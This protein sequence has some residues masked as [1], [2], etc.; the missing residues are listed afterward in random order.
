[1][2][3]AVAVERLTEPIRQTR[4]QGAL[5]AARE[6]WRADSGGH[7][8]SDEQYE[9]ARRVLSGESLFLT[10][11]AGTGKSTTTAFVIDVLARA[12]LLDQTIICGTTG[13]AAQ[14]LSNSVADDSGA[15]ITA[16]TVHSQFKF[17]RIKPHR[18][19]AAK[20]PETET[21]QILRQAVLLII[22][23]ASM[24]RADLTDA[25]DM[26][27]RNARQ[28]DSLFGGITALLVGDLLQ[29]SPVPEQTKQRDKKTGELTGRK[30]TDPEYTK[31]FADGYFHRARNWWRSPRPNLVSLKQVHR[32]SDPADE[33]FVAA[34][35][36][37]RHGHLTPEDTAVINSRFTGR[38]K[39]EV[40]AEGVPI[41]CTNNE[42]MNNQNALALDAL[43]DR[44]G[45]DRQYYHAIVEGDVEPGDLK[46]MRVSQ[47]F[48][49]AVGARVM[50]TTND[51]HPRQYVNGS[52]GWIT[53]CLADDLV[54]RLDSGR[55][56]M[57]PRFLDEVTRLVPAKPTLDAHGK[58]RV[59]DE[60]KPLLEPIDRNDP[61][62]SEQIKA[63]RHT[64]RAT[65]G[66]VEQFPVKLGWAITVHKSQGQT[67]ERCFIADPSKVFAAGQMYVALSR[68]KSL[69]GL[70]LGEPLHPSTIK[71]TQYLVRLD[72]QAQLDAGRPLPTKLAFMSV[73]GRMEGP[74]QWWKPLSLSV[75]VCANGEYT[76]HIETWLH[77]GRIGAHRDGDEAFLGIPQGG[78]APAPSFAQVWEFI[79]P[80]L[81]GAA[82]V[83]DQLEIL[84]SYLSDAGAHA[85]HQP[86][87]GVPINVSD[88]EVGFESPYRQSHDRVLELM[89]WYNKLSPERQQSLLSATAAVGELDD[90]PR[91]QPVDAGAP[92]VYV[93][94]WA[95]GPE[96]FVDM[97]AADP[98]ARG[99]WALAGCP[100][101][102][103]GLDV[104]AAGA[105]LDLVS[106]TRDRAWT[107]GIRDQL[108]ELLNQRGYSEL[109][110][111]LPEAD[112]PMAGIKQGSKVL[113]LFWGPPEWTLRDRG[114]Q[115]VKGKPPAKRAGY[116]AVLC[117]DVASED[118]KVSL[119]RQ[120]GLPLISTPEV[121]R[122][123]KSR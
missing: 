104:D 106:R 47:V 62:A 73:G 27:L 84:E 58:E 26:A 56:V 6:Q 78:L 120:Y 49:C 115:I 98:L 96:C 118:Q 90:A 19:M 111:D 92:G 86:D 48:E 28:N 112:D 89:S 34:L 5:V 35:N 105:L 65:V 10:G 77:P 52:M 94:S 81:D 29:L 17:G 4:I 97:A 11:K 70:E 123:A 114:V 41:L 21:R 103:M 74:K 57:L 95:G 36:H 119:A 45:V 66:S 107:P 88:P 38:S 31:E 117:P 55:R 9:A 7:K 53:D 101:P 30:E 20:D 99:I 79:A 39:E 8:P 71:A 82:L 54:I 80:Q 42:L 100:V 46:D 67:L 76:A 121:Q 93:P 51:S 33:P 108:V 63:S 83:V 2:G 68:V 44:T 16:S 18:S 40:I 15:S 59:D 32:Q 22:D 87:L 85:Y 116:A 69:A 43:V 14:T 50:I 109:V 122:W 25:V 1:M 37:L 72:R 102:D 3:E 12:D 24:F 75:W 110:K 61:D 13:A 64:M 91:W 60:G 23:E 113:S